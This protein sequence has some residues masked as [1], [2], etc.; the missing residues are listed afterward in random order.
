[1]KRVNRRDGL[2]L[3]LVII[4]T[5]IITGIPYFYA[6]RIA[7]PDNQFMGVVVNIPDHFQYFS[8]MRESRTQILVPNQLTPESSTPLLFNL[9]WWVLGRI[10]SLVGLSYATLYQIT[11]LLAG[12]FTM[13]AVY[14]FCGLIFQNRGK[15]WTAFLVAVFASGIGWLWVVY[16]YLADVPNVPNPFTIYTAEP[17]TFY[18]IMAFPHFTIATGLITV[19]FGYILLAQ[20]SQNLR[21][22]WVAAAVA[23]FLSLQHAYDMF[24]IYGVI[25][26]Y[27]LLLWIRGRKF[28]VFMFKT[29]IIV[30]LIS[31]WPALQAFLI[32]TADEVWR[33]VLSQFDNAGAWTPPP[34]LL[35]FLMGISWLLAIWALDIRTP[36]RERD[37]TH[38]FLMAWFLSHFIL[39]YI[40]L[41]FQIH[42]LSGW[43]V[44]IGVMATIGLYRRVLPLLARLFKNLPP[45]RLAQVGTV[46]LLILI[47]P[48]NLYLFGQ[49]IID[50]RR[51]NNETSAPTTTIGGEAG[52]YFLTNGEVAAMQYL[53]SQVASSDVVLSSLDI[54]Q[55][56]PAL[57]GARSFLGHWAQTLD[58]YGKQKMVNDFFQSATSD[59]ERQQILQQY[60]VD[61]VVYS[62]QEKKLGD[63]DPSSASY[64]TE[65]FK[66][67]G[68]TVFKINT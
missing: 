46:L 67:D 55:F 52:V 61:Y 38:L 54:G 25:A 51:A 45:I 17:N 10:E 28:P 7:P 37:D 30:V 22:A 41:N 66:Q 15:R 40:P 16:K 49:R 57:T 39:I 19:V 20:R 64:L 43:Q 11:R 8:W 18:T 58:F 27:G 60:G 62:P 36:W 1:M 32:T 53:E 4:I 42:L 29:G 33:G 47:L 6:H 68:V 24:T 35:P 12:A 63:Y 56:V 3:G 13:I 48:T 14:W 59:A 65:A 50:L 5:L 23:L 2:Y 21:Y 31:V 44:V 9:L 26:M 34:Y